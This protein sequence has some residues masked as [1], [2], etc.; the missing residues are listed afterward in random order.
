VDE[1]HYRSNAHDSVKDGA[2][3]GHNNVQYV[4][5]S[6][7]WEWMEEPGVEYLAPWVIGAAQTILNAFGPEPRSIY[8]NGH[9]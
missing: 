3:D 4:D 1:G 2:A 8:T 9:G 5:S 7:Y 6:A